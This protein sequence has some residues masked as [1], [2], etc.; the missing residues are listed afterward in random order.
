MYIG[1]EGLFQLTDLLTVTKSASRNSGGVFLPADLLTV[2]KSDGINGQGNSPGRFTDYQ[3][4]L[5]ADLFHLQFQCQMACLNVIFLSFS[6]FKYMFTVPNAKSVL[7][8][9]ISNYYLVC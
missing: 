3:P 7:F 2:T 8:T 4:N 1:N 6:T 5:A 9:Q